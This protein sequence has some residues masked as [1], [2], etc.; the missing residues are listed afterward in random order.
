LD[1]WRA[2]VH[3]YQAGSIPEGGEEKLRYYVLAYALSMVFKDCSLIVRLPLGASN[4]DGS[5]AEEAKVWVID[6][7]RKALSRLDKWERQDRE[8]VAAFAGSRVE[9]SC[10]E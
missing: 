8:V 1:E 2:F 10:K 7:E 5:M 9:W 3:R 4:A 6:T